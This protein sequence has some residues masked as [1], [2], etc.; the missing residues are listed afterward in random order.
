MERRGNGKEEREME[1]MKVKKYKR[2]LG[3]EKKK[4]GN[5]MSEE[6]W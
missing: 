5:E 2:K 3:G 1:V 4:K 6:E